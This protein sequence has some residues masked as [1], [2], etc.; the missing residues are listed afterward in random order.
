MLNSDAKGLKG[1]GEAVNGDG[2]EI[3][4]RWE[5]SKGR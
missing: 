2:K 1:G 4:W 5:A 3:K